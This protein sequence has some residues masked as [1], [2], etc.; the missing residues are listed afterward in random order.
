MNQTPAHDQA[1]TDLISM[2]PP[3]VSHI[4]DVGCMHGALAR[5]Y[6]ESDPAARV[7]GVDLDPDYAEVARRHCTN[8]IAGNIETMPD[9]E[10]AQLADAD[11]WV[12]G[13]CIEHLRDP[14]AVLKRIRSVID[15]AGSLVACIPNAQHWS[16][17]WRL[18][19]GNFRYEDSGLLDRT[20][21]RWFTRTTMLEMFAQTGWV[22]E[23]GVT[24]QINT[25]EQTQYLEAIRQCATASGLDPALAVE[26]AKPFQYLFRLKPAFVQ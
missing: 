17:Q 6:R 24:R 10:F 4:V 9:E 2:I 1:N 12:F 25:P 23:Q 14:W 5:V 8:A 22:V 16:V 7:T 18:L 13:D 21:I 26:D 11:C 15:P 20:H 19:S 3:G